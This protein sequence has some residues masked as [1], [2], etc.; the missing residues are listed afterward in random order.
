MIWALKIFFR[1]LVRLPMFLFSPVKATRAVFK[2]E[3]VQSQDWID[4]LEDYDS[5]E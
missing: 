4:I 1:F 3:K 2:R 5:F